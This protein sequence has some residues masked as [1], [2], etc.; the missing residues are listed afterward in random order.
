MTNQQI[1]IKYWGYS[2]FRPMQ[3]EIIN[4]VINGKD[5]LALLPTGGGKSIC[6]QVPAM[7][8]DGVCIVVTPLIALMKDQ[9]RQLKSRGLN[10]LAIYSGMNY[11]QIDVA[12]DNCVFGDVKFLYVSPERLETE[13]FQERL[14][15][16][17]VNILAVDEAHC[18]SQW[19]YDFRPSYLT[20]AEIREFIPNVPIIALTATATPEVV[21]DIQ[22]K[23][24][25]KEENLLQRSF[26]RE[27]LTY[28]VLEEEDK[29]RQL[30]QLLNRNPGSS[31][32]YV[33]SRKA[34]KE[35]ARFLVDNKINSHFYHAGLSAELRDQR[36]QD[37]TTGKIRVI[38][39]TNAFGMGIDKPDVR[40]VVHMD[41]PDS[42]EAYFQEAGRA[43]RDQ[44]QAY[45]FLIY[46][47]S[48]IG[49]LVHN[50]EMKF[51]E[52]KFI[53]NVYNA[54]GNYYQLAEGSGVDKSYD[55]ILADF[56]KMYSLSP[57]TVFYALKYLEKE[58][59][60]FLSDAINRPSRV[61]IKMDRTNLYQFQ[62]KYPKMGD[63]MDVL[64]RSYSALFTDFVT[65]NEATI[66]SRLNASPLLIENTLRQLDKMEVLEYIP[67]SSK[68]QVS[69]VG[70]RMNIHNIR[71]NRDNY[72]SR[73]QISQKRMEAM[74]NY[75]QG[76]SKCR[77]SILLEYF[78]E[79]DVKRCGKCDVCVDRNKIDLSQLEFDS[80]IEQIKPILK[81]KNCSLDELVEQVH[82]V[83]D[84]RII[85]VVR[86]LMDINKITQFGDE[87]I[88]VN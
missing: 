72:E 52:I 79:S 4:S 88:W 62:V 29:N 10:A 28:V 38:V 59:F 47:K 24:K 42:I 8:M 80:V 55:F 84:K 23:L 73:K 3:E 61:Y 56:S 44:Q 45:A 69:L 21:I 36:Q 22:D 19:G 39:S 57:L 1:L 18:I 14:K 60:L 2:S 20:I 74:R 46:H 26:E 32:V 15:R 65:I 67:Y 40:T 13:I 64:I 16:M 58:G 43:G 78:G 34:T 27:N 54:L 30:L 70:G 11:S 7:Q 86:W 66:A 53:L 68:P 6:F 82:D 37:W 17:N 5:T 51:P 48:D 83:D 85:K 49:K 75:V 33:R 81:N 63:F 25:F 41:I 50:H 77:S 12:L 71:I 31:I 9:V 76:F 35:I 87:L